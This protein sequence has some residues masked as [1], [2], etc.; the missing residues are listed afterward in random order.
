MA[1]AL[2]RKASHGVPERQVRTP[3]TWLDP[4]LENVVAGGTSKNQSNSGIL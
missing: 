1:P 2:F 4:R 3:H